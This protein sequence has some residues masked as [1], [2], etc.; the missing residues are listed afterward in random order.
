M[1][2]VRNQP[3]TGG[4]FRPST[5]IVARSMTK[6]G[7]KAGNRHNGTEKQRSRNGLR[8]AGRQT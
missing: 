4:N 8:N 7:S 5:A 2:E 6:R 1:N 3:V